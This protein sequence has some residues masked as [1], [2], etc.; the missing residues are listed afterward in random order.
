MP[1]VNFFNGNKDMKIIVE[2]DVFDIVDR[3][4]EIDDGYRIMHNFKTN[5]L[6]L[7]NINQRNSFCFNIK[8]N[9]I[10]SKIINDIF[11][12]NIKN[13][14]NIVNDIDNNNSEV[15]KNNKEKA[16]DL[17]TY[18][19]KEIFDFSNNSSKEYKIDKAFSSVWR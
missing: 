15:E 3:I 18:M 7:H 10:S 4:R 12:S 1:L 8:N 19:S 14:D 9:E 6:E 16:F 2:S 17:T 13:I 5:M 11:Y